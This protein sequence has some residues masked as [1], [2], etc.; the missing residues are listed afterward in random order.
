MNAS[1]TDR[2]ASLGHAN[3]AALPEQAD[4][5]AASTS[6]FVPGRNCWRVEP[7]TRA[8][9]LV[10]GDAYFKAFVAAARNARR[11][12][13]IMGW[14]FHSRTR[15]LCDDA[16]D[17][18]ELGDFLNGLAR[19]RPQLRIRILTWDYPMI[20][21]LDRDWAPIFGLGWRPGRRVTL[22]YDN[23]HP[24]G[25]SHH[26]K[27]VV[28][29]DVLAFSGGIDL[30]CRRWDTCEHAAGDRRRVSQDE[31]YPPFHD[32]MMAVEGQAAAALGELV[33]QRWLK[34]T[35]Q[36]LPPAAAMPI[37]FW[38]RR[39]SA[40]AIQPAWPAALPANLEA[41]DV[42]ISL[43][44]PQSEHDPAVREVETLYLDMIAA[45][46][47]R[48]YIENQYFTAD[49][50]GRAL[51]QR[52]SEADGPEVILVLR[53]LSHGWL[54]ELTMQTLRTR[55][56]KQ[57]RAADRYDRFRVFYPY[58]AGLAPNTCIDVHSKLM[59]V[60]EQMV[61]IGSANLANRSMG[62]DTECDLTIAAAGRPEVSEQIAALRSRLLGEHLGVAPEQVTAAIAEHGSLRG[63]IAQLQNAERTLQPLADE[64]E[65]SDTLLNMVSV[66][67]PERPVALQD[68]VKLFSPQ[69]DE[70]TQRPWRRLAVAVA[71]IAGLTAL[72]HLTPLQLLLEPQR[73]NRWAELFG[74]KPWAPLVV[75]LAYTPACIV[76]FP[77][78]VITL[79]AVLAFGPWF[80]FLYAMTGVEVAAWLTYVTGQKLERGKV[81]R[82]AGPKLNRIIEVLRRRG[83]IAVTALRLVPLAPFSVEGLVAGAVHIKLWHF[84]LGTA[85]GILPGTLAAT[86]FGDQLQALLAGGEAVNYWLI[87]AAMLL[88]GL[89]TWAV[90][91]WLLASSRHVATEHD[92]PSRRS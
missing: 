84:M 85:I 39:N 83:L 63:A 12:I 50:I 24:V 87:G 91:R 27:I 48:L 73:I 20:F 8:A 56:I 22:R 13:L 44:A 52:L 30:T 17:C 31:T 78:S 7:A 19:K 41:A 2:D 82:L 29:D 25:G 65:A 10:D 43:T 18:P 26:Q 14:D 53:Q 49:K 68:L 67:D 61:R 90:R 45:A 55:L 57:L 15:L 11:S 70:P 76:M 28:I 42:A 80:G 33:R 5:A 72:W 79:F 46:R 35:G 9:F 92:G 47:R 16:G 88:L 36:V 37:P 4:A 1:A 38:R 51:A 32:M 21:G 23:T 6:L 64:A 34:A 74:G 60:D 75:I 89:T 71:V 59:I 62:L 54:E 3:P 81:R 66:A 58:I 69:L 40:T 77:R 86:V